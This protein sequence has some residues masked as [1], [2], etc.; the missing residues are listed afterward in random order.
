MS[1]LLCPYSAPARGP[2]YAGT[3]PGVDHIRPCIQA[4]W[5]RLGQ[6][7]EHYYMHVPSWLT[8]NLQLFGK[9]TS[10]TSSRRL[11]LASARFATLRFASPQR[12][13]TQARRQRQHQATRK[14]GLVRRLTLAPMGGVLS[15]CCGL[16][17]SLLSL[18]ACSYAVEC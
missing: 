15:S 12:I 14:R 5:I 9:L 3:R 8:P 4:G 18:L 17:E 11:Q 16:R 1:T 6:A 10:S 2:V 13:K 7:I